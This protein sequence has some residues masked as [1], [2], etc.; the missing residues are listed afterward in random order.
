MKRLDWLCQ[1]WLQRLPIA[2][3]SGLARRF[4]LRSTASRTIKGVG[5]ALCVAFASARQRRRVG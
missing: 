3:G 5:A 1:T 2:C 4:G